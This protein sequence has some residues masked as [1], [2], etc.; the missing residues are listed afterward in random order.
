MN[1]PPVSDRSSD[2]TRSD[3]SGGSRNPLDDN[4]GGKKGKGSKGKARSKGNFPAYAEPSPR[5]GSGYGGAAGRPKAEG[6]THQ[7]DYDGG[8]G[9][10]EIPRGL[11]PH[12]R[13]NPGGFSPE[14]PPQWG[15]REWDRE[16]DLNPAFDGKGGKPKG[17][18]SFQE[19]PDLTD[20][21]GDMSPAD[22]PPYR[23]K[24]GSFG[25]KGSKGGSFGSFGSKGSKGSYGKPSAVSRFDEPPDDYGEM[26]P[27]G[28]M[29]DFPAPYSASP[30]GSKGGS[31]GIKGGS[32]GSRGGKSKGSASPADRG[33]QGLGNNQGFAGEYSFGVKTPAAKPFIDDEDDEDDRGRP[34]DTTGQQPSTSSGRIY[35]GYDLDEIHGKKVDPMGSARDESPMGGRQRHTRAPQSNPQ[36]KRGSFTGFGKGKD[37]ISY[38]KGKGK[39]GF[40]ILSPAAGRSEPDKGKGKGAWRNGEYSYESYY[41]YETDMSYDGTPGRKSFDSFSGDNRSHP[42]KG[43]GK[44]GSK[45]R[46]KGK[47]PRDDFDE[48]PKSYRSLDQSPMADYPPYAQPLERMATPQS[49]VHGG[50]GRQFS[51]S[52]RDGDSR[53][54]SAPPSRRNSG[55]DDRGGD[56]DNRR[57]SDRQR[58]SIEEQWGPP[59]EDEMS[60]MSPEHEEWHDSTALSPRSAAAIAAM[61]TGALGQPNRGESVSSNVFA[62]SPSARAGAGN[63]FR[64]D[65]KGR[66]DTMHTDGS[67]SVSEDSFDDESPVGRKAPPRPGRT[68]QAPPRPPSDGAHSP[69]PGGGYRKPPLPPRTPSRKQSA[70]S[71]G[72]TAPSAPASPPP[73]YG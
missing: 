65:S 31:F 42:E 19:P 71:P 11:D 38:E 16:Q 53:R 50:G 23:G 13:G 68:L 14:A 73:N 54:G 62:L 22:L 45:G 67:P 40:S 27:G 3:R 12:D 55:P 10:S 52:S 48:T 47:G 70:S 32:F 33:H 59:S 15:R 69:S 1:T 24:G 61:A 44:K 64:R 5:H 20:D 4:R 51:Q 63:S 8:R 41:D 34:Y 26:S 25:S 18:S 39:K 66:R 7:V 6:R 17:A 9:G 37:N 2:P 56:R 28:P 35:G 21:Y 58:T 57:G 60:P 30:K 36:N 29:A 43:Q 46:S 72:G 49:A